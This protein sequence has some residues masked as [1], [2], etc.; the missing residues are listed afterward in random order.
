M[1]VTQ[2]A[3]NP[4][5]LNS[6]EPW[7]VQ[8]I[9]QFGA[10]ALIGLLLL[11]SLLEIVTRSVDQTVGFPR[12]FL[13]E[14]VY[15]INVVTNRL[16]AALAP[17]YELLPHVIKDS[18]KVWALASI[19]G[20]MA[21]S[22]I[23]LVSAII[24]VQRKRHVTGAL[25]I[26]LSVLSVILSILI[27]PFLFSDLTSLEGGRVPIDVSVVSLAVFF[28]YAILDTISW[29]EHSNN[30]EKY[31]FSIFLFSVDLPCLLAIGIFMLCNF[32]MD[33]PPEFGVG[34]SA[35]LFTYYNFAFLF[36]C[37]VFWFSRT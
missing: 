3:V 6:P 17:D 7:G 24:S 13:L 30:H 21:S 26:I 37:S 25:I 14:G 8:A 11:Q 19:I 28:V 31:N 33:A 16:N 35:G 10:F 23:L 1:S 2:S 20:N 5:H 9:L 22:I 36:L 32:Y 29:Q 15:L 4:A 34:V 12:T 18:V 27:T